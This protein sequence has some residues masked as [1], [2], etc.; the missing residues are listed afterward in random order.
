[1]AIENELTGAIEQI[2]VDPI[3]VA[4]PEE[5]TES[6]ELAVSGD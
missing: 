5:Y 3:D 2:K 1:M 4:E 6:A